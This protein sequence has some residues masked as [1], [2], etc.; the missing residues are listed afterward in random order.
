MKIINTSYVK[1]PEYHDPHKWLKRI[2]FYTGMLEALAKKHEVV[3]I[4]RISYEGRVEQN[5]VDYH[6]IYLK[7]KTALF[8]FRLHSIIKK[9][10]PDI[11]L[12]NGFVFPLQIIQL[13][14]TV[15]R[16]VKIIVQ[17]HAEKPST[18]IKKI[19]Q[20]LADHV[21][22]RY[23]FTSHEMG[24]EWVKKGI[25]ADEKKLVEVM[26]A[27]SSF[28]V[29]DKEAAIAKTKVNG[30]PVFLWVGRLNDNKDP[31]TVL[32]AFL[33]FSRHTPNAKLYMIY[34]TSELLPDIKAFLGAGENAIQLIGELPHNDLEDWYN[35]SDFIVSGSHYEGSGVAVCEAMSCGCIPIVTDIASFRKMT[36]GCGILYPAGDDEALLNALMS[37]K[38]LNVDKLRAKVLE[39]FKQELSFEAIAEKI[40]RVIS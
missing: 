22:Q 34:H 13:R 36:G 40:N 23:L 5:G 25:I 21:I 31:L 30:N 32:R 29:K 26:E 38:Q 24:M 1:T 14:L 35:A 20:K 39:Q 8:P 15:G 3:S 7:N 2:S 33:N 4:Q 6:F 9:Y 16:K 11:V 17:N 18:G 37:T 28:H 10:R 19:F 12:V 27:S